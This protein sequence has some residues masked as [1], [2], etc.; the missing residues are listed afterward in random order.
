MIVIKTTFV[1]YND[2]VESKLPGFVGKYQD[3]F[4]HSHVMSDWNFLDSHLYLSNRLPK[5]DA[6]CSLEPS[7]NT[8]QAEASLIV[9]FLFATNCH[10]IFPLTSPR[11]MRAHFESKFSRRRILQ[12]IGKD[13]NNIT[14]SLDEYLSRLFEEIHRNLQKK[15]DATEWYP[16]STDDYIGN[17]AFE[18]GSSELSIRACGDRTTGPLELWG[19]RRSRSD[20]HVVMAYFK[21]PAT[22]EPYPWTNIG[23]GRLLKN[24]VSM[25][26]RK[27]VMYRLLCTPMGDTCVIGAGSREE[28]ASVSRNDEWI[29]FGNDDVSFE[30]GQF[31]CV[32][33]CLE[34]APIF[35]PLGHKRL[36]LAA[37]DEQITIGGARE[38]LKKYVRTVSIGKIRKKKMMDAVLKDDGCFLATFFSG[39]YKHCILIIGK[40]YCEQK[41]R[42]RS[43]GIIYEPAKKYMWNGVH[44]RS[45]DTLKKLGV[46][47]IVDV[48]ELKKV[49]VNDCTRR[50]WNSEPEIRAL[51][52]KFTADDVDAFMNEA[53]GGL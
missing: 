35:S 38:S 44:P 39:R 23:I 45:M 43:N 17:F 50:K 9:D 19:V 13:Y 15:K 34:N 30:E 42:A 28:S 10:P 46:K 1:D 26:S 52:L 29:D 5:L 21:H 27:S 11:D 16:T 14:P 33:Q 24:F 47:E 22:L 32:F 31:G 49:P 12:F 48:C 25:Q 20:F 6:V 40:N 51:G 18:S 53:L 3:C 8:V 7:E 36:K 41:T 37:K 2:A 4:N